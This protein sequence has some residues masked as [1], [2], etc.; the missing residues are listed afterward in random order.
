VEALQPRVVA[1]RVGQVFELV[2]LQA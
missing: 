2:L 1:E